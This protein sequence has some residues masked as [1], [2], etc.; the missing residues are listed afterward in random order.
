MK[1]K[2]WQLGDIENGGFEL[3]KQVE[4]KL[5]EIVGAKLGKPTWV[6]N[7][8]GKTVANDGWIGDQKAEVKVSAKIYKDERRYSNFFETLYKSGK[9]SALLLTESELY[10]TLSPGWNNKQQMMTG[11]IRV[12]KVSDLLSVMGRVFPIVTYDYGD[13]GFYIPNKCDDIKHVWVGDVLFNP[14]EQEYN[15]GVML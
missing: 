11:K 8:P 1:F 7:T 12:W 4:A 15:L 13:Y 3:S 9:P 5:L 10:V 2:T 14:H 6:D